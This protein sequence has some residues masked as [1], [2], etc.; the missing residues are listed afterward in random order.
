LARREHS[1]VELRS[2]LLRH[3]AK[4]REVDP[5]ASSADA[6]AADVEQVLTWLK[7]EHYQS[8]ARFA[9]SRLQRRASS[10]GP[11]RI[12]Q[13]LAMHRVELPE[14]SLLDLRQGEWARARDLWLKRYGGPAINAQ[15]Q[16]RQARFL[17]GR[18]FSSDIVRKL[19]QGK[20][21]D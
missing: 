1:L 20:F 4:L 15:E 17:L 2:K 19:V 5:S 3:A 11:A 10:H 6:F 7:A 14:E 12:R 13:E 9:E 8:D 21:Q 16:A 18:G